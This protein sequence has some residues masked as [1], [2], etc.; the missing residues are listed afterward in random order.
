MPKIIKTKKLTNK[1]YNIPTLYAFSVIKGLVIFISGLLFCAFMVLKSPQSNFFYYMVYVFVALGAFLS[2]FSA[3][4][5]INGRGFI[6]GL[7]SSAAYMLVII[8]LSIILMKFNM[9]VN[10]LLLVPLCLVSGF[11][12]GN[13]AVK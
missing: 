12:G 5:R 2:G 3:S 6:K 7:I 10:L 13:L 9:S 11:L 4:K 1:N 8:I